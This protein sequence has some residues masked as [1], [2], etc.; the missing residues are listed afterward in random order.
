MD[1]AEI[2]AAFQNLKACGLA[3]EC[4]PGQ[5]KLSEAGHDFVESVLMTNV[6]EREQVY[7][8]GRLQGLREADQ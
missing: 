3:E 7:A 5:W 6:T 1:G 2:E 4:E 8:L